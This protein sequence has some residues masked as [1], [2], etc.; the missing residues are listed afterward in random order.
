MVHLL[1][2]Y[3]CILF[4]QGRISLLHLDA[5]LYSSHMDVLF[6][7]YD[8]LEVGGFVICDDCGFIEEAGRAVT[9]FR[10]LH[11]I[12]APQRVAERSKLTRY[13]QKTAEVKIEWSQLLTLTADHRSTAIDCNEFELNLLENSNHW[14]FRVCKASTNA[15]IAAGFLGVFLQGV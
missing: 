6:N 3:I 14:G 4:F 1:L 9:D 10:I 12:D 5:D 7:L 11:A 8:L 13:W 15:G 2:L